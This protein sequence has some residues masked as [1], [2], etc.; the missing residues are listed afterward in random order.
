MKLFW[1]VMLS[2]SGLE[3]VVSISLV[4]F[5]YLS[6]CLVAVQWHIVGLA[7][8]DASLL[9]ANATVTSKSGPMFCTF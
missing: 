1:L 9:M 2:D 5:K 3:Y 4:P 7:V 8:N 6:M